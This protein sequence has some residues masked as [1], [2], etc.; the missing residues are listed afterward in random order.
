M[1]ISIKPFDL[2]S[3]E[4]MVRLFSTDEVVRKELGLDRTEFSAEEEFKFVTDWCRKKNAEQFVIRYGNEFAGMISL[5]HIDIRSATART[6]YWIGSRFRNKSIGSKAF[7]ALLGIAISKGISEV[8]SDI[9]KD[10]EYSL[11]IW[12][13]YNPVIK[14]KDEK[15]YT[16]RMKI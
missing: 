10:N 3:A 12:R 16:V 8:R 5:S 15:Q 7:E 9:D 1:Q 13:K 14:E 4:E 2:N 11:R 6:G